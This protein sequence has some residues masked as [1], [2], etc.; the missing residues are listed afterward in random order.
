[1]TIEDFKEKF[2][3]PL[4]DKRNVKLEDLKPE[5]Q[6]TDLGL[7]SLDMIEVIIDFEKNF[8]ITIPDEDIEKLLTVGDAEKYLITRVNIN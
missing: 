7:N 4:I 2:N 6:F 8:N 3:A 5:V 1:M